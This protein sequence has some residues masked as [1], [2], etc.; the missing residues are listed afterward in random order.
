M[1]LSVLDGNCYLTLAHYWQGGQAGGWDWTYDPMITDT[2]LSMHGYRLPLNL[3]RSLH[4]I[5]A[6]P[7]IKPQTALI[8]I[9]LCHVLNAPSRSRSDSLRHLPELL[10]AAGDHR[11][12]R[13]QQRPRRRR[14][15]NL[16]RLRV[17]QVSMQWTALNM[18]ILRLWLRQIL[19]FC[20]IFLEGRDNTMDYICFRTFNARKIFSSVT[21][22]NKCL[23]ELSY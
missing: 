3:Q 7:I 9:A 1:P 13:G 4:Y 15:E 20:N 22:P 23:S 18:K 10:P 14:L 16:H 12:Q 19:L 2:R 5:I 8:S 6:F 17:L 11:R 21:F